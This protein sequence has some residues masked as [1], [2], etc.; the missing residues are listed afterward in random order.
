MK[1]ENASNRIWTSDWKEIYDKTPTMVLFRKEIDFKDEPVDTVIRISADSRYK[2]YINEV[3]VEAGPSKGDR[4][5]WF[6]DEIDITSFLKKGVNVIAVI[7]L[8]YPLTPGFGNQSIITT[9]QPGLYFTGKGLDIAGNQYEFSADD[10]WNCIVDPR[11]KIE[12]ESEG[13]SPMYIY[14][15]VKERESLWNWKAQTYSDRNWPAAIA[16]AKHQIRDAVSPGNLNA[17][18]IPFLYKKHRR[19]T[20]VMDIK[21]SLH[22]ITAW[23]DMLALNQPILIPAYGK[24]VVEINA[25]EE[26]TGYLRL[27]LERGRGAV[28]KILQSEAY[29]QNET[30]PDGSMPVKKDRM[31][32]EHGHLTGYTDMYQAAGTGT[33]EHQECYEPF[34]FRTFR[35]IQLEIQT[36]E[37][38]LLIHGFDYIE[39]GYPLDVKTKVVTSDESLSHIWEISER[40][41]R[42]CMHETY[43]D[44]PFYEQL[45]YVMDTRAQILYTYT[46]AAD[47]RLARKAMDDMKRAQRYDGLLCSA[48]PN[49]RPNVIP[50]FSIFYILML[51]DHM[52]YFGDQELIR[53]HMPAVEQVLYFFETHKTENGYIG[54]LGGL[55]RQEKFWSFID[56]T[57]KWQIGV[58]GAANKGALTMESLLYIMG[59]QHGAKLA[60]FIGRKELAELYIRQAK[61]VQAAIRAC[62]IGQDGLVQDGP[63]VDEYSQHCQVFSILTNTVDQETGQKNLLATIQ[64]KENYAQ[65][66]VAMALYLFRALEKANL[67]QYT[68][69]Y[70]NIWREMVANHMTTCAE[71]D[72]YCRSECHAWGALALYELPA[73][74][75]GVR[76]AAPGF[77]KVCIAPVP[78]HLTFASGVAATPKGLI[79]VSWEKQDG[80]LH[81]HHIVPDGIEV[82]LGA[83][84]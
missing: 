30:S 24:E 73:V 22:R 28:V 15:Q 18:T 54:K 84:F 6:W 69:E 11:V 19:F 13:F 65:C 32:T 41:L 72:S 60:Q 74:I 56:W 78:G 59:L 77:G 68:D 36:K 70:W 1:K 43:E 49:T 63:G 37:E 33:K 57:P 10:T 7:V 25:G 71:S 26:M 62:C 83:R 16:F 82:C 61:E 31:D 53:Y 39:T 80:I 48:Y 14:E 58:P 76:P 38:P 27:F 46:A 23:E 45:Q 67:Y 75:L 40:T 35:F 3:F 47:D 81:V 5:I 42:R 12:P 29:V 9:T 21:E 20:G 34:W 44:C 52:M 8:R 4:Q 55:Y 66:S 64:K 17:R 79:E 51:Y 2:L 50:G